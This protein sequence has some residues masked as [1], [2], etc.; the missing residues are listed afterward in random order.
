MAERAV[1][2]DLLEV[3]QQLEGAAALALRVVEQRLDQRADRQVLVARVVEQAAPRVEDA[4]VGLALA[5]AHAV[6]DLQRQ[7]LE[8]AVPQDPRLEL[9]QVER[10]GEDQLERPEVVELARVHQAPGVGGAPVGRERLAQRR[11]E[12]LELGDA[13]AVLA[14]ADAAERGGLAPSAGRPR[15]RPG[16]A[17]PGRST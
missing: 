11:V 14:R 5:A 13:D 8:L 3:A 1:V 7:L 4:A 17:S 10:G 16:A 12:V 6:G 15:P 2:G 9:E